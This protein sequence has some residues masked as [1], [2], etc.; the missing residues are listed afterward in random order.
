MFQLGRNGGDLKQVSK[1]RFNWALKNLFPDGKR[2]LVAFSNME[3][4]YELGIVSLGDGQSTTV[5]SINDSIYKHL[6]LPR[7]EERWVDSSDG[8]KI[9]C[10]VIYPP[11]FDPNKKWPM[12]TYCQGGPQ[13]QIGQWFSYRWNFHLM[14]AN[15]YVVL[16]PNRRGLPGFGRAWNDEISGDWAGQ[17]MRD[18]LSATDEMLKEPYIAKDKVAAIGASYGGYTVYWMMGNHMNRFAAMVAHCGVFNMEAMYGG[19]EELFFVNWELGGPYWK[20]DKLQKH[21]DEISPHRFV[22]NWETPLL[23]IHGEKDF[24]IP[25][26]QGMDAFTTAQVKGVPSRFLYYPNEGHWVLGPQN[27]ILWHRIFFDWVGRYCK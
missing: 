23:V 18:I 24:R 21:Y 13:G 22:G 1:G 26:T 20:S 17:P 6:E 14:A 11:D 10:W 9:H 8:K 4:P 12:L 2:A 5:S 7:V 19:T 16:A 25:S 27:G 15:G 3:R